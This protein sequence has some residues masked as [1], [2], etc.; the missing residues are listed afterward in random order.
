MKLTDKPTVWQEWTEFERVSNCMIMLYLHGFL[1]E[2]EM[3]RVKKR[4]SKQWEKETK[5]SKKVKTVPMLPKVPKGGARWSLEEH[6]ITQT[7]LSVFLAC[8]E[9]FRIL[10]CEGWRS[11]K[12]NLPIEFGDRF[13]HCQEYDADPKKVAIAWEKRWLKPGLLS[14]KEQDEVQTYAAV[15]PILF[16]NWRKYWAKKNEKREWIQKEEIFSWTHPATGIKLRGKMDGVI[17]ENGKVIY[18]HEIKTKAIVDEETIAETLPLD[19]QTMLYMLVLRDMA[20]A[21]GWPSP[22]GVVYDVIRRPNLK[23]GQEETK[24]QFTARV[25][26]DIK[27][28]QIIMPSGG[29]KRGQGPEHYYSH[30]VHNLSPKALDTFDKQILTPILNTLKRWWV[31]QKVKP[32]RPHDNPYHFTNPLSLVTKYGK[33]EAYRAIVA[34][35]Y[36]D[37]E[38]RKAMFPELEEV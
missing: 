12:F 38:P 24:E 11:K 20:K 28:E 3:Q 29:K 26:G 31:E 4:I 37:L 23:R 33:C 5:E 14:Q 25:M 21:K 15:L 9:Q 30:F 34:N 27:G 7:A 17:Q 8:P 1:S 6:G 16:D 10:Y 35:D 2:S 32:D 13:H 22:K 19:L 18:L 36:S